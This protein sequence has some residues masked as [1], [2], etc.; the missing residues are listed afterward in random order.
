MKPWIKVGRIDEKYGEGCKDISR[1]FIWLNEASSLAN[2]SGTVTD[3][4]LS[5]IL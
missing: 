2:L 1:D 3:D 5:A 4:E